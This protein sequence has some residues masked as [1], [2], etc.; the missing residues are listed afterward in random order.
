MK[1]S[2]LKGKRHSKEKTAP[3][4]RKAK[5]KKKVL[6]E[7][8][9]DRWLAEGGKKEEKEDGEID[10]LVG[11]EQPLFFFGPPPAIKQ[12]YTGTD[13]DKDF[14]PQ[15]LLAHMRNGKTRSEIIAGWGITYSKFNSWLDQH[16]E[17]AEAYAVGKPAFDAYHKAALRHVAFG[18]MPKAKEYSVHFM[19]KNFAGF[20]DSGGGHEYADSQQAELE[21]VDD[22]D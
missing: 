22:E 2:T 10:G 20:D 12:L 11:R 3:V 5:S 18:Q 14:H 13:Y 6:A 4:S 21:F 17:L 15:D 16:P 7:E 8:E 1:K 9:L 19:L